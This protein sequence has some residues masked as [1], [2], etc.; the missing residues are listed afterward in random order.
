MKGLL[1]Y[2]EMWHIMRIRVLTNLREYG[3]RG[4]YDPNI[5]EIHEAKKVWWNTGINQ[6]PGVMYD[7]PPVNPMFGKYLSK[8]P[9]INVSR[10]DMLQF[11]IDYLLK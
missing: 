9:R 1:V 5:D 4:M 2:K 8:Y 6:T 7:N 11:F 3:W 10:N